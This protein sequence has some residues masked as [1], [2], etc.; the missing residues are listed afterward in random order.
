M[1]KNPLSDGRMIPMDDSG[2]QAM[3]SAGPDGRESTVSGEIPP[4]PEPP[5]PEPQAEAVNPSV[6]ENSKSETPV[7]D[8]G[9]DEDMMQQ[10][11]LPTEAEKARLKSQ[12]GMLRVVPIPY[13]RSDGKIQTYILR[14]LTRSQ[15][16]TQEEIARKVAESKPGVSADEIFQEKIVAQA[17]VWPDL[18]EHQIAASPPG[19]VPTLFGV[20]QQMGLFFNPEAI[21]AVTFTL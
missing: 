21:M 11:A 5:H 18:Q 15:W 8:E 2:L 6:S 10:M 14:Q 19:L 9:P 12:Y 13:T 17:C 1:E 3:L 20:V 16:R 7:P 4:M